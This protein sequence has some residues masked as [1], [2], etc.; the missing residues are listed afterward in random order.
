M[1]PFVE[2]ISIAGGIAAA[3]VGAVV[4]LT[5]FYRGLSWITG[6][7]KPDTIAVRG[8]LKK[9]TLATVHVAG[10]KPFERV[11]FIGFTNSQSMKT[12]LPWEL[13]GMVI[14]EDEASTRFLVRAKDIK[15]IIV[16]P[17]GEHGDQFPATESDA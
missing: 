11:R 4:L 12:H 16:P 6:G 3:I 7:E 5:L 2:T 13:N 14:F 9:D 1:H 17:N 8:V 10:R 15:M